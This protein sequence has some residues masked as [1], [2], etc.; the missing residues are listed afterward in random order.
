MQMGVQIAP[1]LEPLSSAERASLKK[2]LGADDLAVVVDA[3]AR[4][5]CRVR[6]VDRRRGDVDNASRALRHHLPTGRLAADE[7]AG[8]VD[9]DH[10]V[11][12]LQREVLRRLADVGAGVVDENVDAAEVLEGGFDQRMA[13][14]RF[15]DVGFDGEGPVAQFGRESGDAI[16]PASQQGDAVAVCGQ[17]GGRL[18]RRCRTM[19]R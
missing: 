18:P 2:L 17:G 10:R 8:E 5:F 15:G 19:R 14:I 11:P 12:F 4:G 9:V 3:K 13:V 7:G 6:V 1:V 16:E